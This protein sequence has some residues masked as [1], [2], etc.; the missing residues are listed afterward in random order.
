MK[1]DVLFCL[2]FVVHSYMPSTKN[3]A[4]Y[5]TG[6]QYLSKEGIHVEVCG[7]ARAKVSVRPLKLG[8]PIQEPLATCG[9]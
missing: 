1:A 6:P 8:C 3:K 5:M 2:V 9:Y 7:T 4:W